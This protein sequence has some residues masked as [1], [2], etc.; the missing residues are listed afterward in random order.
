MAFNGQTG[1]I[2]YAICSIDDY[3]ILDLA[4]PFAP[5]NFL[6]IERAI[7]NGRP[8]KSSGGRWLDDDILDEML[9]LYGEWR[10]RRT[11]R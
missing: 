5:G 3:M 2:P 6:E 1:A 7:L 10:A 4:H 8:H 11:V 9:T